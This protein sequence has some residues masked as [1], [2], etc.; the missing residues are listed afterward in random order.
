RVGEFLDA[1]GLSALGRAA[2]LNWIHKIADESADDL[3][4]ARAWLVRQLNATGNGG[5]GTRLPPGASPWQRGCPDL[6]PGLTARPF[7]DA[8]SLPWI[9]DFEAA[10][11]A[12]R[13]ELLG[14]RGCGGFQPYRAP[15][16]TSAR[17]AA[18]GVGHLSHDGGDW[19]IYYLYL[20]N[21]DFSEN[22]ARCPVTC[23]AL[24]ALL[25]AGQNYC[26]AFFSALAPG[27]HI[28]KHWGPTNKKLRLHLPLVVP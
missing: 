15:S 12:I 3:Q 18:D 16:W 6:V 25:P 7:W 1:A 24:E 19:S 13:R 10:F 23:T 11:P 28:T 4:H 21:V 5:S 17:P 20:H 27:T 8:G 2:A 22:R 9:R 26:H 14:L